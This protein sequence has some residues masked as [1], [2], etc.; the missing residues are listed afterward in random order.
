M[1][2]SRRVTR[3]VRGKE[4][5][6][7]A[8]EDPVGGTVSDKCRRG[9]TAAH[10]F[11]HLGAPPRASCH[12]RV[13]R[14]WA[15]ALGCLPV[16]TAPVRVLGPGPLR[17][18]STTH[19][20]PPSTGRPDPSP[21]DPRPRYAYKKSDTFFYGTVRR[22]LS[23]R[24]T[25]GMGRSVRLRFFTVEPNRVALADRRLSLTFAVSVHLLCNRNRGFWV[26]FG[27]C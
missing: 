20:S 2:S 5:C 6:R 26:T 14:Y 15:L 10:L 17:P 1:G 8:L 27:D 16:R 13:A 24:A 3:L 7:L 21:K 25:H 11:Y 23:M 12:R 9:S 22:L 4:G 19:W 18:V